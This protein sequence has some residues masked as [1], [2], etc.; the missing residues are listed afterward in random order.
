MARE[1]GYKGRVLLS[2]SPAGSPE[3][4]VLQSWSLDMAQ[5]QQEVTSFGDANKTYVT[6]LPDL[7]G[8]FAGFLDTADDRLFKAAASTTGAN[9]YLYPDATN[10]AGKYW[11]G[12]ANISASIST[13][14]QAAI[15]I[16]G[17]FTARGSW[18]RIWA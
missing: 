15:A 14:A 10:N 1:H 5:D 9:L 6:G 3:V 12:L 8:Q 4:I 7:S 13:S 18:T 2:T 16:S 17:N 11:Y